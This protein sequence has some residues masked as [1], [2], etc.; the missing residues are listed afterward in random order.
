MMHD[1]LFAEQLYKKRGI[2][3]T[4]SNRLQPILRTNNS[5]L[6]SRLSLRRF[7][8]P[9][10]PLLR[11]STPFFFFTTAASA[12]QLAESRRADECARP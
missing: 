11:L 8:L 3:K 2:H 1:D 6:T 12:S 10:R 7:L 4:P 9:L 5:E